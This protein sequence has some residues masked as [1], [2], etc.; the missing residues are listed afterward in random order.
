MTARR[1]L[2]IGTV[3]AVA[4]RERSG[5]EVE[6]GERIAAFSGRA[7]RAHMR[8]IGVL[9][10]EHR[11]AG[12]ERGEVAKVAVEVGTVSPVAH[13]KCDHED[14]KD[15]APHRRTLAPTGC[16]R[17]LTMLVLA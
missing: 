12:V 11:D 5:A 4:R 13:D 3:A 10:R 9:L 1:R 17:R 6:L 16:A 7:E 8:D 2:A 14:S 15:Q